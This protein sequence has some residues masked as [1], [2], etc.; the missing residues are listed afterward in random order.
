MPVMEMPVPALTLPEL[1]AVSC[2]CAF[3]VILD[4]VYDPGVTVVLVMLIVPEV[5][6][7]L[8]G[9]AVRPVPAVMDETFPTPKSIH[10]VPLL[11]IGTF[12]A[13][14][15]AI[16]PLLVYGDGILVLG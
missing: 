10:E 1:A 14:S 12:P 5:V 11:N 3:T 15:N 8:L 6:M 13:S 16:K 9:V 2:P 7:G 4:K